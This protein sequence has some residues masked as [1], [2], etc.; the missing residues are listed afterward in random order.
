MTKERQS[1]SRVQLSAIES[2][3][4]VIDRPHTCIHTYMYPHAYPIPC[5]HTLYINPH[6]YL[7]LYPFPLSTPPNKPPTHTYQAAGSLRG[8]GAGAPQ[9]PRDLQG[10][11]QRHLLLPR[12][13]G[14]S[15]RRPHTCTYIYTHA[16]MLTHQHHLPP[17]K[18][19]TQPTNQLTNTTTTQARG[20]LP[21]PFDC[22][23]AYSLGGAAAALVHNNLTGYLAS[24]TGLKG[25]A[26]T[27][28]VAGV[29]LTALLAL[30]DDVAMG[31][32]GPLA[33]LRPRVPVRKV[34]G[35][36][37]VPC[38]RKWKWKVVVVVNGS[39][40]AS[41]HACYVSMYNTHISTPMS[42]PLSM[43]VSPKIGGPLR[44]GLQDPAREAPGLGPPRPLRKRGPAAAP[45][46][47]GRR[48][49]SPLWV[50]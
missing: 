23:L 48:A 37:D 38:S 47:D 30:E 4:C 7:Y 40:D 1:D 11:L 28:K 43:S 15:V 24:I 18:T 50:S 32:G 13:P 3:R 29:P 20:S 12:L 35:W 8:A 36:V 5:M 39:I 25:P 19:P 34:C 33:P 6:A 2:E 44:G 16:C 14:P 10:L 27:W 41:V 22:D 9:G 26:H 17:S 21:S 42:L 45:G 31:A 49:V 46:Q